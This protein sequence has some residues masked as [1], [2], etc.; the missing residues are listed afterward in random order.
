MR[1]SIFHRRIPTLAALLI[2]LLT[3]GVS[4]MLVRQGVFFVGKATPENEPE[5]VTIANITDTSF[6]VSFTTRGKTSAVI[7]MPEGSGQSIILDDRDKKTGTDGEYF[8]HHVTVPGLKPEENYIFSLIVSGKTFSKPEF[9]AK[10]GALMTTAPPQQ[11]PV[12]GKALL[13]NGEGAS[14]TLVILQIPEGQKISA[15][16]NDK[17]DFIIPTNSIRSKT[18]NSYITLSSDSTISLLLLREDMAGNV[19]A[20]YSLSQ[21]L[22]PVVLEQKYSFSSEESLATASSELVVPKIELLNKSINISSPSEGQNFIDNKPLFSGTAYPNS[23]VTIIIQNSLRKDIM[24]NA[25]GRWSFR[26]TEGLSQGL[27]NLTVE[28]ADNT[29]KTQRLARTFFVF[30]SGSQIAEAATPSATPTIQPTTSPT[31]TAAQPTGVISTPTPTTGVT[32]TPTV[33]PATPTPLPP[34]EKPGG[35]N[36]TVILTGV[37]ILLMVAG[38]ILLFAL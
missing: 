7:N 25:S 19:T 17:G 26:P 18:L 29:G 12:V 10:T 37:S 1:K 6:T 30:P 31:P 13:P 32:A 16:T 9:Q 8:S 15:V 4:I 33:K 34:I 3:A 5:N 24:S 11:N 27:H 14:D 22:P 23:K 2:F 38:T 35:I 28:T 36:S 21:N 20:L